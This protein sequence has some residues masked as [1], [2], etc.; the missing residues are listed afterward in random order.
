MRTRVATTLLSVAVVLAL[1]SVAEL[2]AQSAD[3][4]TPACALL[5]TSEIRQATGIQQYGNGMN[6]DQEG[7]GVGGGSSCL[8]GGGSFTPGQS[9]PL[10]SLVLIRGKGYT[11]RER[12][13][14]LAAGCKRE[15]VSGVGEVAFFESCP[16]DQDRS[17]TL[18]VKAGS[19]DL[20]VDIRIE[21]PVTAASAR[22]TVINVAKA[23]V[24]KLA[25]PQ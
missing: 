10:L 15:P 2:S 24:A 9:T 17:A 11:E 7:E 5:S 16:K 8:W 22:T 25:K 3:K 21:P 19:N 6:G 12:K 4:P 14:K 23:A 18:Y 20:V 13:F 1:A